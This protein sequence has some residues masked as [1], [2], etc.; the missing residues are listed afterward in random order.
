M[1]NLLL[2]LDVEK[3]IFLNAI[4]SFLAF[5]D[6]IVYWVI[7]LLFR[8]VFNLANFEL[9]GMFEAIEERVFVI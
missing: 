4:R 8:S 7:S 1:S 6:F 3:N 2:L 5:L 9:Y